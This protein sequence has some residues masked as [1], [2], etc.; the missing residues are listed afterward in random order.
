MIEKEKYSRLMFITG[1]DTAV[2]KTVITALLAFKLRQ[3][4]Y[5]VGIVKPVQCAGNDAAILQRTLNLKDD[6]QIINPFFLK[7]PLSPHLAFKRAGRKFDVSKIKRVLGQL[8]KQYDVVLV[9]GAGGLLVPLS[10]VYTNAQL[11]K[12]LDAE[13]I[14]VSRLALGTINH[15]LLTL[16]AA[17][18]RK[19]KVN[20][21]IFN[22]ITKARK[23]VAESTNPQEIARIA[24]VHVLATIPYLKQ[25]TRSVL[26][27]QCQHINI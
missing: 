8:Q 3:Q 23:G 20:G 17:R 22:Q 15:T 6:I 18:L 27:K 19:L 26:M 25:I 9:E 24:N 13:L 7:E 2:G 1:T 11:V 21:I 10:D 14:I 16:E 5:H 12:D 4:G